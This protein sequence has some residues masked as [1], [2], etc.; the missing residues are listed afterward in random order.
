MTGAVFYIAAGGAQLD[1]TNNDAGKGLGSNNPFL[2]RHLLHQ[3]GNHQRQCRI[4]LRSQHKRY[5][6]NKVIK[7]TSLQNDAMGFLL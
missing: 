3:V 4:W 5:P 7:M 6:E 1:A 2:H